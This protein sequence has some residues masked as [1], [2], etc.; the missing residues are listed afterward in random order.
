MATRTETTGVVDRA[1]PLEGLRGRTVPLFVRIRTDLEAVL[2][3]LTYGHAFHGGVEN[4]S[5]GGMFF[6]GADALDVGTR[7]L[8]GLIH[9]EGGRTEE[10]YA[11]GTVVHRRDHGVGIAFDE[12]TPRAFGVISDMIAA[13]G[14]FRM[15]PIEPACPAPARGERRGERKRPRPRQARL[16]RWH[17]AHAGTERLA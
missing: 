11:N 16:R 4:L 10:L 2:V 9:A 1:V 8:C 13:A 17:Q 5:V 15:R 7:V 14:C 3:D 6:R 12:V